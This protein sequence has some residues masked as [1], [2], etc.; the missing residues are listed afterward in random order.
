MIFGSDHRQR[1]GLVAMTLEIGP[2][3][4]SKDTSKAAGRFAIFWQVRCLQKRFADFGSGCF[5]HLLNTHNKHDLGL[6]GGNCFQPF[7][8]RGRARCAGIFNPQS[9]FEAEAIIGLQHQRGGKVLRRETPVKMTKDDGI[10]ILGFK[11]RM[12]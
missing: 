4:L 12:I 6:F 5:R 7:M 8:H 3:N 10:D 11:T 1:I 9:W 2:C